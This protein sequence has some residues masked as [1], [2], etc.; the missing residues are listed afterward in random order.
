MAAL[1]M[2]GLSLLAALMSVRG[3]LHERQARA[4]EV[5][6]SMAS[7][8]AGTQSINGPLLVFPY[9]VV[10]STWDGDGKPGGGSGKWTVAHSRYTLALVP[11]ELKVDGQLAT[12]TLKRGIFE[13]RIFSGPIALTG[14]FELP[15][16]NPVNVSPSAGDGQKVE[17]QWGEPFL[18]LGLGDTRGIR[19]LDGRLGGEAL[20]FTSGTAVGWQATGVHALATKL[21]AP[22]ALSSAAALPFDLKLELSGSEGLQIEP[23]AEQTRLALRSNWQHPS[24]AGNM[25]PSQR[26]VSATGFSAQWAINQLATGAAT[27]R[28]KGADVSGGRLPNAP[29]LLQVAE[30]CE[31]LPAAMVGVNLLDPVDRYLLSERTLKYAVLFLL[32]V[33]AA[34]FVMEVVRR[35]SVHPVQYGLVGAALALFFLLTLALSEH[36]DFWLAYWVAAAACCGLL[37]YY[38]SYVLRGWTA[39]ATFGGLVLGLFGLLYAILQSENNALLLGSL[40]LFALLATIMVLT[41]HVDWSALNLAQPAAPARAEPKLAGGL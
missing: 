17:V 23:A 5:Q 31:R 11:K 27:L 38:A 19:A 29:L 28:C 18:V 39:G 26:E 16:A 2:V 34:V 1:A 8:S 20:R 6:A 37:T 4:R 15:G 21:A 35:L 7:Y 24:F 40:A 12:E 36:L 22:T 25:A 30:G 41:R 13:A 9:R 3:L 14:S 32:L 33:F 10:T